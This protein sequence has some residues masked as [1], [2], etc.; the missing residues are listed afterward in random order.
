MDGFLRSVHDELIVPIAQLAL[1]PRVG[2]E[3]GR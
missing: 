2:R 3:S 1:A